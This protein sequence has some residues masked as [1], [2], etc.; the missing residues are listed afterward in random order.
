MGDFDLM[1]GLDEELLPAGGSDNPFGKSNDTK[2]LEVVLWHKINSEG[3]RPG[4]RTG[5]T[6]CA[7]G[8]K[9]YL[10]GGIEAGLRMDTTHSYDVN[11]GHWLWWDVTGDIPCNRSWHASAC[12]EKFMY[13]QGGEAPYDKISADMIHDVTIGDSIKHDEFKNTTQIT[14]S[15]SQHQQLKCVDDL[16]CLNLST[17][18]W[19]KVHSSLAPLPRKGHS[20][21]LAKL[22]LISKSVTEIDEFLILFGGLSTHKNI[23]GNSVHIAKA[24]DAAE[25]TV[26]WR[27]L[28]CTG[29]IP[30]PRYM[31]SCTLL[32]SSG[33]RGQQSPDLL[34]V[35][36]GINE[37]HKVLSDVYILNLDTLVWS[38]AEGGGIEA[39]Q[40][41]AHTAF[42][43]SPIG[44]NHTPGS[45]PLPVT[46]TTLLIFGGS[47][48]SSNVADETLSQ[49]Y[50][51]DLLTHKWSVANTGWQ[52]PSQRS[53]H[54]GAVVSGWAPE[55]ALPGAKV[56]KDLTTY[57]RAE[58]HAYSAIIFGGLNSYAHCKAETWALDL[59]W[60]PRGVRQFDNSLGNVATLELQQMTGGVEGEKMT[61]LKSSSDGALRKKS[62]GLSLNKSGHASTQA[63]ASTNNNN[64]NN[65]NATMNTVPFSNTTTGAFTTMALTDTIGPQAEDEDELDLD[66]IGNAI[67]RVRKDR[68]MADVHYRKEKAR[69]EVAEA[70]IAGVKEEAAKQV[71]EAQA[72]VEEK[73][74]EIKQLRLALEQSVK[75]A[76]YL[77]GLNEEAYQILILQ[78]T[79]KNY[80]GEIASEIVH[81]KPIEDHT[82]DHN[83]AHNTHTSVGF[84]NHESLPIPNH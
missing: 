63:L 40:A 31:H 72:L 54:A 12:N 8:K 33:Q 62:M 30:P 65:N 70:A 60:R 43:A 26:A 74:E 76:Q 27:L 15:S 64:N 80:L 46:P 56:S 57:G 73:D 45:D 52:F 11:T 3:H 25:G 37:N 29:Q 68:V 71:A 38:F 48:S 44:L 16:Y 58:T 47:S 50:V 55:N 35:Y 18:K 2:D 59:Q 51:Y 42:A 24:S 10:F 61:L 32:H 67:H 6:M 36:G 82:K 22:K 5:H 23:V 84:G 41:Y 14:S 21:N 7:F 75:R 1:G 66:E 49:M 4:A 79:E 17:K 34:V 83:K 69:A 20:L 9:V 28:D 13:V 53:S 78:G 77:E 19:I 81:P 39:P